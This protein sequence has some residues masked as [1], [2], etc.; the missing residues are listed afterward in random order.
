MLALQAAHASTSRSPQLV[1]IDDDASGE[2]DPVIKLGQCKGES[3]LLS[4]LKVQWEGGES[5]VVAGWY[6]TQLR[7][8]SPSATVYTWHS[9]SPAQPAVFLPPGIM[10]GRRGAGPS[11]ASSLSTLTQAPQS[12]WCVRRNRRAAFRGHLPSHLPPNAASLQSSH[13]AHTSPTKT[14]SRLPS[15]WELLSSWVGMVQLQCAT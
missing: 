8:Q 5:S 3:S 4:R 11:T 6:H 2:C 9:V 13:H 15:S 7:T 12:V 10:G 14:S 1:W